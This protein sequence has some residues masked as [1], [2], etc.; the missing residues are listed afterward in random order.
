MYHHISEFVADWQ[1]ETAATEKV[2]AALTDASLPQAVTPEGRTL[3]RLAW[4]ITHTL[5]EMPHTAGLLATDE[6]AG[7]PEPTMAA[8]IQETYHRLAQEVATAATR[9]TDAELGDEVPMYGD[10]W[11]KRVVLSLLI[12]HEIHHRGQ[13]TVLMRQAGLRVPGVY[14]PTRDDWAEWGMP[15][16]A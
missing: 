5:T 2:L 8:A 1:N 6:L 3:G 4:H 7:Q 16:P 13:M 14:G 12:R 9:W 15:V 10:T 11:T